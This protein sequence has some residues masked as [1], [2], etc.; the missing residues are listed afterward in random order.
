MD[1][2]K[3]IKNQVKEARKLNRINTELKKLVLLL[4]LG[5]TK[6]DMIY[7]SSRDCYMTIRFT[8]KLGKQ[9]SKILLTKGYKTLYKNWK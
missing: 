3:K 1:W 2:K 7:S 6:F 4:T 5:D 8:E 9:T